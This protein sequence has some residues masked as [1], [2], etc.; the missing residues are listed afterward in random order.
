MDNQYDEVSLSSLI[1]DVLNTVLPANCVKSGSGDGKSG[2]IIDSLVSSVF[3]AVFNKF[4]I[5]IRLSNNVSNV[6]SSCAN[7]WK[8]NKSLSKF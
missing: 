1:S 5:T 8:K 2:S 3:C 6:A 4:I 7:F